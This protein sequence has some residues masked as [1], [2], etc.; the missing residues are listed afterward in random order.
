[1]KITDWI[2]ISTGI[3]ALVGSI[4]TFVGTRQSIKASKKSSEKSNEI[5]LKLGNMTVETQGKQRLI[6][7]ISTQRVEWINKIREYFSQF[8]KVTY[9]M[10]LVRSNGK[11]VESELQHELYYLVNHIELFLNP[12]EI[13]TKKFIEKK[14]VVARYL[15]RDNVPFSWETYSSGMHDLHYIEQVILKAEWKRLKEETK[16][17]NE[18][19]NME[20]IHKEI[21]R[22]ID[23]NKYN[24]VL[25][26]DYEN[27][28]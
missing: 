19:I 21:A 27:N 11:E 18:V 8:S 28:S 17:G 12:T 3:I 13:I 9:K 16:S 2:A 23:I 1:M 20:E 7:T 5:S 25:R 4:L 15:L 24:A 26:Q 14:D 6:E 10:A 22:N